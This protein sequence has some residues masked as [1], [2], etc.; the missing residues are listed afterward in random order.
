MHNPLLAPKSLASP[1]AALRRR[2]IHDP[3]L[4]PKSLASPY[5]ALAA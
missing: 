5:A 3:L 2:G 1:Y 4:A